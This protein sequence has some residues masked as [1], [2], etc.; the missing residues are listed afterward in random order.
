[1]L[2]FLIAVLMILSIAS[3]YFSGQMNAISTA[4]LDS[5]NKAVDLIIYLA[6]SM[7]LWGGIMKIADRSGLT[8]KIG[9]LLSPITVLLFKG[10]NQNREAKD[11]VTM[12]IAANLF[13]LGNAATPLGIA[14]AKAL[15]D[16]STHS[17]R[18]IS[19]LVVLNT[20]SIQLIP[21][22][23]ASM[24]LAHGAANP[25]DITPAI[26]FTSLIS[27]TIGCLMVY[28]LSLNRKAKL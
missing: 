18:N 1:M 21:S 22:T 23:I 20:A 4:A 14:A 7:A 11:A 16:G 19:M 3:G 8:K 24:R 13:G 27:T 25:F 17:K 12:N 2:G 15:D 5:C 28:T 6:G 10:I 9:K 26:L